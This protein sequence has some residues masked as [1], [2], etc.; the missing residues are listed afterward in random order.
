MT[1]KGIPCDVTK[2]RDD[3]RPALTITDS[4]TTLRVR[5]NHTSCGKRQH[6]RLGDRDKMTVLK[7]QGHSKISPLNLQMA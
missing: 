7:L 4:H 6:Q 3:A 1:P 5:V 2:A